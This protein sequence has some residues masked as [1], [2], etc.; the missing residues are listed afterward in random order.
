MNL[1][2]KYIN[3]THK[4]KESISTLIPDDL[5]FPSL[6]GKKLIFNHSQEALNEDGYV[7]FTNNI[8]KRGSNITIFI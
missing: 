7:Q 3:C 2:E 1:Y 6:S 4:A 8:K 5:V